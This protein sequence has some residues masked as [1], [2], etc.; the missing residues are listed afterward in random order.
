MS[1]LVKSI[2]YRNS[3]RW[4]KKLNVATYVIHIAYI[5]QKTIIIY[6]TLICLDKSKGVS[7]H[8]DKLRI[9]FVTFLEKIILFKQL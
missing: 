3:C 1:K 9:T 7:L 2:A 5:P 4:H 8:L 6:N